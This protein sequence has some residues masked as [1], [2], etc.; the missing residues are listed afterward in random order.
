MSSRKYSKRIEV[1]AST[2]SP[3]GFAGQDHVE[4]RLKYLWS[5]IMTQDS[6]D[7]ENA[8]LY[9]RD[10]SVQIRVRKDPDINWND[11]TIFILYN[12]IRF[13]VDGVEDIN[14]DGREL[15]ISVSADE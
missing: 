14:Y 1:W 3:N 6:L 15:L 12:G 8:G 2:V 4:A 11:E 10:M 9:N 5:D 7:A 13:K